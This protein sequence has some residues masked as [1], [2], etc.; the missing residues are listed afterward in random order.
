MK[1]LSVQSN[2]KHSVV[3]K[4]FSSSLPHFPFSVLFFLLFEGIFLASRKISVKSS[5][6]LFVE[7]R[8]DS[9]SAQREMLSPNN[10]PFLD[11]WWSGVGWSCQ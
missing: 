8:F 11:T 3:C 6:L 2:E 1:E 4:S 9:F 7:T 5:F 10:R